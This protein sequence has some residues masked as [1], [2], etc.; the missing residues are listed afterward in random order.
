MDTL[1][2]L[3]LTCCLPSIFLPVASGDQVISSPNLCPQK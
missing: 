2:N 3:E 1:A